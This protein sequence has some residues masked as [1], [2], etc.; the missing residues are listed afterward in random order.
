MHPEGTR[1]KGPDSYEFLPAQ[2]GVG[3]LALLAKPTVM[4]LFIR[5]LGNNFLEDVRHNFRASARRE[6]AVIAVFGPPVDY[7]DLL[8]DK[9]RPTLYKKC[10]DRFM[11]AIRVQAEREKK[12]R[13]ELDAGRIPPDDPR[14][15][16]NR[17]E[18]SRL[19]AREG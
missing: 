14:W 16:E 9:P 4:P 3:K 12:L 2:P 7:S 15:I 17:G 10:A 6:N 18:V 5:G 19:Y 11:E 13:A 8:A 1:G